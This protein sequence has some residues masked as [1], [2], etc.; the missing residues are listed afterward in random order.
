M[1]PE[2]ARDTRQASVA[3]D[4]FSLGATLLYAATGHP[5]IKGKR[6]WMCSHGRSSDGQPYLT[7]PALALIA[8]YQRSPQPATDEPTDGA[9]TYGDASEEATFGS[10]TAGHRHRP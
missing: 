8:D 4:V 10:H 7:R 9:Q 3:S 5:P 2:Q 6:S 1:A